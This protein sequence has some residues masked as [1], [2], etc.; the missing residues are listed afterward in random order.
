M[1]DWDTK[2]FLA[3]TRVRA[4]FEGFLLSNRGHTEAVRRLGS[5]SRSRPRLVAF[6]RRVITDLQSGIKT[7]DIAD[8]LTSDPAFEF[9]IA[10]Q[11]SL[12]DLGDG[13]FTRET[14]G[15]AFIQSALPSAPKCPT[16][17]GFLHTN[18]MQVGH[19][20]PKRSGGAGTLDN[21]AMQHPF[22]N[23]TVAN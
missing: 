4:E 5:G 1:R 14:K 16:C 6:Y 11:E 12:L 8:A 2:Q 22:C 21:A 23:S 20:K 7:P 15:A 3:F 19:V 18:G 17:G 9:F 13:S 10:P